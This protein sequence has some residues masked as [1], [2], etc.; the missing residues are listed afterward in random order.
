MNEKKIEGLLGMAQRAGKTA[1]GD[2]AIRKAIASGQAAMLLV[3]KDASERT[4]EALMKEAAGKN[5][6][7]HAILTKDMLGQCLGKAYRA[8]VV[9]LD[10]GFAKA[11]EK[12]L[13]DR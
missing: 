1:S 11:L 2:V 10:E 9:L 6:P 12:E 4:R 8:S 13:S 7:A 5:I 3:A